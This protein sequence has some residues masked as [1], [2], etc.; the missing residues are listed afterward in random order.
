M[1]HHRT[2]RA[3]I[4]ALLGMTVCLYGCVKSEESEFSRH[5]ASEASRLASTKGEIEQEDAAWIAGQLG[6][7]RRASRVRELLIQR[8]GHVYE[9]YSER[10]KDEY[11]KFWHYP[12]GW[13]LERQG[14]N[15]M[16]DL[17]AVTKHADTLRFGPQSEW[18]RNLED[19]DFSTLSNEETDT[20]MRESLAIRQAFQR[21]A[22]A[23]GVYYFIPRMESLL[24]ITDTVPHSSPFRVALARVRIHAEASDYDAAA[25]ELQIILRVLGRIETNGLIHQLLRKANEKMVFKAGVQPLAA[26]GKVPVEVLK[27]WLEIGRSIDPD[28]MLYL[29]L[30]LASIARVMPSDWPWEDDGDSDLDYFELFMTGDEGYK[31]IEEYFDNVHEHYASTFKLCTYAVQDRPSLR[32]LEGVQEALALDKETHTLLQ[33]HIMDNAVAGWRWAVLELIIA[34]REHGPLRENPDVVENVLRSWPGLRAEWTDT[35]LE[36]WINHD[37][38]QTRREQTTPIASLEPTP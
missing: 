32:S 33:G 10:L 30:D 13:E 8:T 3:A 9:H 38:V 23:D 21:A 20:F 17:E 4:A 12:E 16:D 34:E 22:A 19:F 7:N 11:P 1:K 18:L 37:K 28:M 2:R 14:S 15:G 6:R 29:A 31:S 26:S 35:A 25:R 24:D 36:L 5:L 27:E